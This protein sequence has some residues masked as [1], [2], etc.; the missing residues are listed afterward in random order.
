MIP[1]TV[2]TFED[3]RRPQG[4]NQGGLDDFWS[5]VMRRRRHPS[6]VP[7]EAAPGDG[8]ASAVIRTTFAIGAGWRARWIALCPDPQCNGAEDA[9]WLDPR[10]FCLACYNVTNSGRIYV[11]DFPPERAEIERAVLERSV[12][13]LS[14]FDPGETVEELEQQTVVIENTIRDFG[15]EQGMAMIR[16]FG[17]DVYPALGAP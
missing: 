13:E 4:H 7:Q 5:F 12:R 1:D 11:V 15:I 8:T 6:V 9:S 14:T 16:A 3:L 10:F 17:R 2:L